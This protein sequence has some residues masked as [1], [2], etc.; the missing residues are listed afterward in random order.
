MVQTG[1]QCRDLLVLGTL[2]VS[3][4]TIGCN[5]P[6]SLPPAHQNTHRACPGYN[7][8]WWHH[9][10]FINPYWADQDSIILIV[11]ENLAETVFLHLWENITFCF[12]IWRPLRLAFYNRGRKYFYICGWRNFYNWGWFFTNEVD[13]F[14]FVV[15]FYIMKFFYICGCNIPPDTAIEN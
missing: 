6:C 1:S 7:N 13:F 12:C 3:F 5:V 4:Y 11:L 14:T 9:W 2:T 15:D 8:W 10:S